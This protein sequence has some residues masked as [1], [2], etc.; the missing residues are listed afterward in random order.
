MPKAASAS[1]PSRGAGGELEQIRARLLAS[2]Q[3]IDEV[4][5]AHAETQRLAK[6]LDSF[7]AQLIQH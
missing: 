4:E 7:A 2:D 6:D 5:K 1:P 3:R